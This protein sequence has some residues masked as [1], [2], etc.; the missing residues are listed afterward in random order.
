MVSSAILTVSGLRSSIASSPMSINVA[1]RL[2][3]LPGGPIIGDRSKPHRA[4][5][6]MPRIRTSRKGT[7]PA[8]IARRRVLL[9]VVVTVAVADHSSIGI[10]MR[11]PVD[12][13]ASFRP[14]PID[15]QDRRPS[16]C[17]RSS[18]SSHV[19]AVRSASQLCAT[20]ASASHA[21]PASRMAASCSLKR[22]G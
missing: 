8:R 10:V 13:S 9:P 22:V 20:F 15:A 19:G 5:E 7:G 16:A 18:P 4:R 11:M 1:F 12:G 6:A 17:N 3:D 2:P 21:L 14:A